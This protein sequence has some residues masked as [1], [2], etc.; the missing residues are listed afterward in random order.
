MTEALVNPR[1][2]SN[3]AEVPLAEDSANI[4]LI[5]V[6]NNLLFEG[7]VRKSIMFLPTH[8]L[9]QLICAIAKNHSRSRHVTHFF[10]NFTQPYLTLSKVSR[11][12]YFVTWRGV[13]S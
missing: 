3:L 6:R 2:T 12:L 1:R 11:C 8:L 10:R 9:Q 4:L 13:I 7:G 5:F